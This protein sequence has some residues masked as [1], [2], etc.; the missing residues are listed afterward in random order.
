MLRSPPPAPEEPADSLGAG[1]T[2]EPAG[3]ADFR[4]ARLTPAEIAAA[5]A[6]WPPAPPLEF[7]SAPP[8]LP[9]RAVPGT[10]PELRLATPLAP[11]WHLLGELAALTRADELT[12]GA[13][14]TVLYADA[15]AGAVPLLAT[16]FPW[17]EFHVL[18]A[19]A[20][21]EFPGA[22]AAARERVFVTAAPPAYWAGRGDVVL[23]A[24]GPAGTAAALHAAVAPLAALL[25][26]DP[27][28]P[29]GAPPGALLRV[30]WAPL[31]PDAPARLFV[32][33]PGAAPPDART[34]LRAAYHQNV[35]LRE[36][37]DYAHG[38][39]PSAVPG[40]CPC[41]DCALE[42]ALWRVYVAGPL[43]RPAAAPLRRWYGERDEAVSGLMLAAARAARQGRRVAPHGA[44]PRGLPPLEKRATLAALY[45]GLCAQ[46]R[47]AA[48]EAAWPP[49]R[50]PTAPALAP[51]VTGLQGGPAPL[52]WDR[53]GCGDATRGGP[54]RAAGEAMDGAER[55]ARPRGGPHIAIRFVPRAP[56]EEALAGSDKPA[57]P[58][59]HLARVRHA[60]RRPSGQKDAGRWAMRT[61]APAPMPASAPA[62]LSAGDLA[63]DLLA[64]LAGGVAPAALEA[65]PARREDPTRP[66]PPRAKKASV[67]SR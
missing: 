19:P 57:A 21:L 49:P 50:P 59:M 40:L 62:P 14:L 55:R 2:E 45:G 36:W 29:A 66:R 61:R 5:P 22:L 47:T 42:V 48:L 9:P 28:A 1:P 15:P 43:A 56:E 46:R 52:S 23:I 20:T 53:S 67:G 58:A 13:P 26:F 6:E 4:G 39:D 24:G 32:G 37:G 33:G 41:Y 27:C 38:L 10:A 31:A 64:A 60:E 25:P 44:A 11:L 51:V 16:L 65:P 3:A 18:G 54:P 17:H 7:G 30:P 12:G 35:V 8:G 63:A 34:Y